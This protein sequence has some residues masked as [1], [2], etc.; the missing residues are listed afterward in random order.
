[1][2]TQIPLLIQH[3][4]QPLLQLTGFTFQ[5]NIGLDRL[6]EGARQLLALQE[7]KDDQENVSATSSL[8]NQVGEENI[9]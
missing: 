3:L 2:V 6:C 8:T 4:P 5:L 1:M 7:D 9:G